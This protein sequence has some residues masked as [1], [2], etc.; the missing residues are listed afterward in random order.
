M[1]MAAA[2][3]RLC[4]VLL[5]LAAPSRAQESFLRPADITKLPSTPATERIFYGLDPNQYADLRL[6]T[7]PGLHPVVV[8]IHGG[9]WGELADA[10]M[11]ANFSSTLTEAGV[12]TWNLEYRRVHNKG[13]G[14]PGTFQDVARGMDHLREAARRYPLDL[15]RVVTAGHSSGGHL[16]LWAAARHRLPKSSPLYT[17]DPLP[18]RGAVSLA[19]VPDLRSFVDY[20]KS[21]CGDRHIRLLGGLPG[22][23]PERYHNASPG[24]LLPLG[25][26]QRL[27]YGAKD[28]SVPHDLFL[29]YEATA[30]RKGD[31]VEAIV[32]ESSAHFDMLS[33]QKDTWRTVEKAILGVVKDSG[34]TT[35]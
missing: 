18:V 9:C 12:A 5:C 20:G 28:R 19:G 10:S 25:V 22:E 23:V 24:E 11:L 35:Q 4:F 3:L 34:K 8:V 14:W 21:V 16:A 17:A 26:P 30:R 29:D 2:V 31:D 15:K 7:G 6:P 33:P 13:S 32:I 27:I 1:T